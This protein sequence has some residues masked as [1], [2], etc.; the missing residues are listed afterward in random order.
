MGTIGPLLNKITGRKIK[1][2]NHRDDFYFQIKDFVDSIIENKTPIVK[3]E[4]ALNVLRIIQQ[5][6]N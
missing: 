2:K 3:V 5:C 6:D 4:E 1:K